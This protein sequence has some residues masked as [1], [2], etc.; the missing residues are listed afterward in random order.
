MLK[1][2]QPFASARRIEW[3]LE[4]MD[5]RRALLGVPRRIFNKANF[6]CHGLFNK[7]E[8]EIEKQ[9]EEAPNRS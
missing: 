1:F 4:V 3:H 8:M 5:P 6:W 7:K 2:N 9:A